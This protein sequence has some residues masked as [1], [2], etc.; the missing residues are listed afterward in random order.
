MQVSS[1]KFLNILLDFNLSKLISNPTSI[2]NQR[3]QSLDW[4]LITWWL[5]MWQWPWSEVTMELPI[6]CSFSWRLNSRQNLSKPRERKTFSILSFIE[7]KEKDHLE[8]R[9]KKKSKISPM[10]ER[11]LS[12]CQVFNKK[13][14]TLHSR[15]QGLTILIL[16]YFFP[17]LYY[18]QTDYSPPPILLSPPFPPPPP[19]TCLPNHWLHGWNVP[20]GLCILIS[21]SANCN[22]KPKTQ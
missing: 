11:L 2:Y 21:S 1:I 14:N 4:S 22:C 13:K 10:P 15:G 7:R 3:K 18:L 12:L 20:S 8:K 16:G 5:T 9:T 17:V 6:G 19:I